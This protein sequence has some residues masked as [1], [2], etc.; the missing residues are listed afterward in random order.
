V[1]RLVGAAHVLKLALGFECWHNMFG[2]DASRVPG[3]NQST[4]VVALA[5]R[6]P[7]G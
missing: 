1:N 3:A 7:L 4:P 2:K 5:D 6:L